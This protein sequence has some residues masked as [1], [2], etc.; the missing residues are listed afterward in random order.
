MDT[1]PFDL[2]KVR[3]YSLFERPSKVSIN[4]LGVPI[5][6]NQSISDWIESL[7]KQLAAVELRRVRD[8]TIE[9]YKEGRI[10][11]VAIGGHVIKTGCAPYL[12]DL[13]RHGIIRAL[14]I[15]GA[16]AIHDFELAY[17]GKTSEDV[18]TQLQ[19]G[20]F[21]MARETA[22][23]F[24]ES[25]RW[26]ATHQHGL[27][28][29]LGKLMEE[30]WRCPYAAKSLLVSAYR[31]NIPCTVHIAIGTDIVH[32]HPQIDASSLGISALLDFKIL[33]SIVSKM[34][35]GIW[36]NIGSAVI[37]PEIFL[38]AV[39]LAKNCNYNLDELITVNFDKESKYR[40][41]A[42]VLKRPATEGIE[43]IGHHELLIP[44]WYAMIISKL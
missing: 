18:A 37:M 7:P 8:Y 39:A 10:I 22:T 6:P 5:G 28:Y 20:D 15:N 42:N 38:K 13:M 26:A 16:A 35:R 24:A 33:C 9:R 25:A 32:M 30:Q 3:T 34:Y 29:S 14:A 44:L 12:I 4:D 19:K 21:G 1:Q 17:A 27:G 2:G 36:Y 11:A 23:I 40:T 41:A 31:M 43:I